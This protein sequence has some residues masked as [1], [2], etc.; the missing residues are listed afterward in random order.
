[1]YLEELIVIALV[2]GVVGGLIASSRGTSVGAGIALGGLLGLIG[3][4]IVL[5]MKPQPKQ[6]EAPPRMEDIRAK[7]EA[8]KVPPPP[9]EAK[10]PDGLAGRTRP[11]PA[12]PVVVQ[13]PEQTV[14]VIDGLGE[15]AQVRTVSGLTVWVDAKKLI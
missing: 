14:S 7:T 2:L 5:L 6:V 4:I 8:R 11:H 3:I 9:R 15:W 1:M 12:E 13:L 10:V